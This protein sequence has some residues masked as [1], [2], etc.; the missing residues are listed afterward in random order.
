MNIKNRVQEQVTRLKKMGGTFLALA[1]LFAGTTYFLP[2]DQTTYWLSVEGKE[3][4]YVLSTFFV[5]L[6]LYCF[7]AVWRRQN[8]I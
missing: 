3:G 5:F 4:F 8:F 7:G 6:G 2:A 1:A